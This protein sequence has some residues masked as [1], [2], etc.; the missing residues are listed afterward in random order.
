MIIYILITLLFYILRLPLQSL[1]FFENLAVS[2]L[3]FRGISDGIVIIG[4]LALLR[5]QGPL[6][7]GL[8]GWK[9]PSWLDLLYAIV[10]GLILIMLSLSL[11]Q[12]SVYNPYFEYFSVHIYLIY[13]FLAIASIAEELF[14]RGFLLQMLNKYKVPHLT[15]NIMSS[16]IFGISHI[17]MGLGS[18][19]F[20][21][22]AGFILGYLLL[23]YK[24][25]T[26]S[27]LGHFIYNA[28]V[29]T[30]FIVSNV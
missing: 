17:Y 5:I 18:V 16:V 3:L 21:S 14:F 6:K 4:I 1:S 24:S 22:I 29:Y 7:H 15:I 20:S 19:V 9:L 8:Y 27:F 10:C 26:I 12:F 23:R 13:I 28:F 11:A 30:L 2:P 25:I